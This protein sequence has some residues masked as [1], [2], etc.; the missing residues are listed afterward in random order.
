ML[1]VTKRQGLVVWVYSLKQLKALRHYGTVIYASRRMK[2]VYLYLDMDQIDETIAKLKKLRFV[3]AVEKSERPFIATEYAGDTSLS[4][5][6]DDQDD[7]DPR[8]THYARH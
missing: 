5:L 3:K 6:E 1:E 8:R 7:D 4:A 2:Y